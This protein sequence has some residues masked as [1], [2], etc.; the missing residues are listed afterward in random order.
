MARVLV[1]GSHKPVEFYKP[2]YPTADSRLS[3]VKDLRSTIAW[4]PLLRPTG[5]GRVT[6]DFYTADRGGAYDVVIEGITDNGQV[7]YY[8]DSAAIQCK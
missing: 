5:D 3:T 8:R 4:E 1:R 2:K 7:L 6:V